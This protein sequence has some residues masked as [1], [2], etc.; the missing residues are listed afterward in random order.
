MHEYRQQVCSTE[1]NFAEASGFIRGLHSLYQNAFIRDHPCHPWSRRK[2]KLSGYRTDDLEVDTRHCALESVGRPDSSCSWEVRVTTDFADITDWA[3]SS[4]PQ[5]FMY[6]VE[7]KRSYCFLNWRFSAP[8]TGQRHFS[9][10]SSKLVPG[11]MRFCG[12]PFEGSY[13]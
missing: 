1:G 3:L 11:A 7:Q 9:G 12:S 5:I 10:K 4:S 8:Q 6:K 13:T 2:K